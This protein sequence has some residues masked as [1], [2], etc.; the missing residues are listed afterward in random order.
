METGASA[1]WRARLVHTGAGLVVWGILL[2]GVLLLMRAPNEWNFFRLLLITELAWA[3]GLLV[4]LHAVR[5]GPVVRRIGVAVCWAGVL[6]IVLDGSVGLAG[7]SWRPW[8]ETVR[9]WLWMAEPI[10]CGFGAGLALHLFG[11]VL[12]DCGLSRVGG[13]ARAV[14]L[15]AGIGLGAVLVVDGLARFVIQKMGE[16]YPPGAMVLLPNGML[17]QPSS[18]PVPGWM[19]AAGNVLLVEYLV[20]IAAMLVVTGAAVVAGLAV[21]HRSP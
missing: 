9:G 10:L 8:I 14:G 20:S 21:R 6:A 1:R 4:L 2:T 18:P 5:C 3:A 12:V 7:D 16:P 11:C 19:E 13:R 17:Q 15:T